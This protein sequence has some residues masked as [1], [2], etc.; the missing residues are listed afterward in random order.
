MFLQ[1]KFIEAC[2]QVV[3]GNYA[4]ALKNKTKQKTIR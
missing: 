1:L 2:S 3:A 4:R